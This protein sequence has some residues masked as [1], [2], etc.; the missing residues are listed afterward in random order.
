MHKHEINKPWPKRPTQQTQNAD[1]AASPVR[2][3]QPAPPLTHWRVRTPRTWRGSKPGH[4]QK[5]SLLRRGK[6]YSRTEREGHGPTH[7]NTLQ[8]TRKKVASCSLKKH[9]PSSIPMTKALA[10]TV[11]GGSSSQFWCKYG[12]F[13]LPLS[14][15]VIASL[16]QGSDVVFQTPLL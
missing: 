12:D 8:E 9:C 3:T 15:H 5:C 10:R 2:K 14:Q 16:P 13:V 4:G 1:F 7:S 11:F 6:V